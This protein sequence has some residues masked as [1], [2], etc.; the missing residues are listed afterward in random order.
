[1]SIQS[2]INVD[3][4]QL[5]ELHTY[6]ITRDLKQPRG[7]RNGNQNV[8]ENVNCITIFSKTELVGTANKELKRMKNSL[9][10]ANV[11]Q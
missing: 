9:V 7:Q 5:T 11:V 6:K 1:M 8:N 2:W 4:L 10:C 3:Q